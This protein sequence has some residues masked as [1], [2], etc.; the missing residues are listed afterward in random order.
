MDIHQKL[1]SLMSEHN[2]T[3]YRLAKQSGLAEST[4]I[5]IFH[6]NTL[7]T[8]PTLEAICKAFGITLAQFFAEGNW[9][10]LSPEQQE[11]F[12]QWVKLT[13]TQ[14]SSVVTIIDVFCSKDQSE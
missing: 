5:N 6:R 2:W 10:E 1:Q 7:P 4:I 14:K 12:T 13:P 9:V 3:E 8:I 11:L